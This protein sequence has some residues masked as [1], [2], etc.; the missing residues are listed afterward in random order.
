M[1]YFW[2]TLIPLLYLGNNIL[3]MTKTDKQYNVM[4]SYA[5][6]SAIV[7][8]CSNSNH[9]EKGHIFQSC[10]SVKDDPQFC[11]Q[12]ASNHQTEPDAKERHQ[13]N[14]SPSVEELLI[15]GSLLAG[16]MEIPPKQAKKVPVR[17]TAKYVPATCF[18]I[19]NRIKYIALKS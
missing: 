10:T 18:Q 6:S 5:L 11:V 4:I 16:G 17:F 7:L 3:S 12:L 2:G 8:P 14:R 9:G 13:R 1:P 15:Q 19:Y